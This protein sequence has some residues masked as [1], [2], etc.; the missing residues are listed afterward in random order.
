MCTVQPP[1]K[2]CSI[3]GVFILFIAGPKVAF[4]QHR[5][6]RETDRQWSLKKGDKTQ[7]RKVS[8]SKQAD[9]FNYTLSVV[10]C[11][12]SLQNTSNT[13]KKRADST[14][15]LNLLPSVAAALNIS[16]AAAAAAALPSCA[17]KVS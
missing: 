11:S 16:V 9:F 4:K 17:A 1:P 7:S 13:E 3:A 6:E 12:S 15:G 14:V 8:A 2:I 10:S 5:K